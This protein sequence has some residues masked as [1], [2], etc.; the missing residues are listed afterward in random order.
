[1]S[2]VML[3][4][5]LGKRNL[6]YN[7]IKYRLCSMQRNLMTG[8]LGLSSIQQETALEMSSTLELDRP[9]VAV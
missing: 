3:E 1:M 6:L 9:E 7:V 8:F 4:I 5:K 2:E